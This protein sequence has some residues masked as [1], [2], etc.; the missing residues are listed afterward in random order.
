MDAR[1]VRISQIL[2]RLPIGRSTFWNWVKIGKAP[3]PAIKY[4]KR[5]TCWLES[6]IDKFI[7]G[8]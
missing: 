4:G 2:D 3:A 8:L 5:C 7:K 6:D 1:L